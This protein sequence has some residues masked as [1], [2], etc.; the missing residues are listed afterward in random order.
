MGSIS[1]TLHWGCTYPGVV[2]CACVLTRAAKM[3]Q[4][5]SVNSVVVVKVNTNMGM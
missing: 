4:D 3:R 5:V 1:T 2:V